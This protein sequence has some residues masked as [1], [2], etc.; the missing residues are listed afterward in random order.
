[1]ISFENHILLQLLTQSVLWHFATILKP[2]HYTW[3]CNLAAVVIFVDFL[4]KTTFCISV[5]SGLPCVNPPVRSDS[6]LLCL[7]AAAQIKWQSYI[8][9]F[10]ADTTNEGDCFHRSYFNKI[11]T[12][13]NCK[14]DM[15]VISTKWAGHSKNE[16]TAR[17]KVTTHIPNKNCSGKMQVTKW[18][19]THAPSPMKWSH[20]LVSETKRRGG[21]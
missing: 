13:L 7:A 11:E 20:P 10:T 8:W 1:M 18:P 6:G 14:Y 16:K 15:K 17:N 9:T 12:E 2:K 19:P 4:L 21:G 3:K 5:R